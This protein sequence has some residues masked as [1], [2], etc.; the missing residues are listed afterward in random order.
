M[1]NVPAADSTPNQIPDEGLPTGQPGF[2]N[3]RTITVGGTS[4]TADTA[5][6]DGVARETLET[7]PD[8][9]NPAPSLTDRVSKTLP[10]GTWDMAERILGILNEGGAPEGTSPEVGG[11]EGRVEDFE[12]VEKK[13][14]PPDPIH[15]PQSFRYVRKGVKEVAGEKEEVAGRD[16]EVSGRDKEVS[17]RDKEVADMTK[18]ESV[19]EKESFEDEIKKFSLSDRRVLKQI[20][21]AIN[22]RVSGASLSEQEMMK[23]AEILYEN[24]DQLSPEARAFLYGELGR[25]GINVSELKLL[26]EKK[27]QEGEKKGNE[28]ILSKTQRGS[29]STQAP[30]TMPKKGDT[31]TGLSAK[32][33]SEKEKGHDEESFRKKD[34]ADQASFSQQEG[35]IKRRK[36][37]FNHYGP[38][39]I[40]CL[41]AESRPLTE[42]N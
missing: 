26:I 22:E 15:E 18:E 25:L 30:K 42:V 16:K 9:A 4:R 13:K 29:V 38:R 8:A 36:R 35:S 1:G 41:P 14:Q 28:A 10:K 37:Q 5:R 7:E 3:G 17:G 39:S 33:K 27:Q 21:R 19:K 34:E 11:A 20:M 24:E 12:L 23:I 2:L 6:T 40:D 32:K 31:S